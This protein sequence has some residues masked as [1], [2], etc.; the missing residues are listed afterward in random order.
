MPQLDLAH[1]IRSPRFSQQF[2]VLRRTETV[3]DNGVAVITV[4]KFYPIGTV[5]PGADNQLERGPDQDAAAKSI[6]VHSQFRL[7]GPAPGKKPDYIWWRGSYF[8]V[9]KLDDLSSWGAGWTSAECESATYVDEAPR[10][11]YQPEEHR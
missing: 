3:G 6:T 4:Q 11:G 8:L 2:T 10:E 9:T 5:V 1:V 7:Q